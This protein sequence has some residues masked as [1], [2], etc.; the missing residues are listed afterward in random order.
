MP[1]SKGAKG[2]SLFVR[3]LFLAIPQLT[4]QM[5]FKQSEAGPLGPASA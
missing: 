2:L 4:T 1:E 5:A 3:K